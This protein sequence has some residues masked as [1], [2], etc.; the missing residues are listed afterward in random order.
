[1]SDVRFEVSRTRG[2]IWKGIAANSLRSPATLA[3][4]VGGSAVVA[5]IAVTVSDRADVGETLIVGSVAFVAMLMLY[6]AILVFCIFLAA[7][8]TWSLPGALDPVSYS[9]SPEGLGV[10]ASTGHGVTAWSAWKLAFETNSLIV[11]R[12]QFNLLHII[13]KRDLAV[14]TLQRIRSVLTVNLSKTHFKP[15]AVETAS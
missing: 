2:D 1:M 10:S 3:W 15:A 13:P 11:I 4:Y 8:K 12:H 5:A 14:E 9:L 7:Q 6:A